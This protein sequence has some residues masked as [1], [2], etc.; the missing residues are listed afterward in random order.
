MEDCG[1]SSS[2][3]KFRICPAGHETEINKNHWTLSWHLA[4][5]DSQIGEDEW[6]A[7]KQDVE[8]VVGPTVW[9]IR[10]LT[11]QTQY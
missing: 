3:N 6:I 8:E 10:D 1:D 11:Y 5:K 2:D 7:T 4:D 9:M